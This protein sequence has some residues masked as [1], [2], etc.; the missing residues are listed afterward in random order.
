V[1]SGETGSVK[2]LWYH[3]IGD[4][5]AKNYMFWQTYC[6]MGVNDHNINRIDNN[7]YVKI[8]IIMSII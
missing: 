5:K 4:T 3:G 7:L 1:P 8:H 6:N 2:S